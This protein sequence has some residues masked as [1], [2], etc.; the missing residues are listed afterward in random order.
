VKQAKP[1]H[2][3]SILSKFFLLLNI[4]AVSGLLM[5]YV[6]AYIPPASI[7][8]LAFAGLIYPYILIV[9]I[10]FVLFWLF[11]KKRFALISIVVILLGWNQ[12]GRL[13]RILP[14]SSEPPEDK[15]KIKVL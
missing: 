4:F 11:S 8:L 14:G 15:L 7:P 9:N 10:G 1:K 6:S 12:I 3:I 5:A 13:V 2:K